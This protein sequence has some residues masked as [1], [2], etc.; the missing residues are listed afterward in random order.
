MK[1]KICLFMRKSV[2]GKHFSIENFYFELFKNFKDKDYEIKFKICPLLSKGFLNRIYLCMWAFFNQGSINHICGDINFIS[3]LMS[4]KKTINTFLDFYSMKRLKGLK[5]LIYLFFWIKIPYW[6]SKYIISISNYTKKELNKFVNIKK[7]KNNEVIG[8]SISSSFK[9]RIKKKMSKK[10]NIIVIGTAINK[11]ISNLILSLKDINCKLIL[12][13]E[14]DNEIFEKLKINKIN[15]INLI[16]IKE[17]KLIK[18]YE[19]CDILLFPSIYEG[20][21]MPILEAQSIGRSVITSK[22]EPMRSV[23]GGG[24]LLVNPRNIKEISY[25]IKRLINNQNLRNSL[26]RKGFHNVKQYRKEIILK[27]HLN[28]Y[29]KALNNL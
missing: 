18:K 17:K 15:Y 5:R 12:V 9:K 2:Q 13:G 11:N 4:K 27:K 14:I 21:G 28:V 22:L 7:R 29:N 20:F 1:K 25:A 16:S 3:I 8:V 19:E 10:P 26:I 23:A 24:A 6:K